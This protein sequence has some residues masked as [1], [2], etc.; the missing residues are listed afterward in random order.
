MPDAHAIRATVERYVKLINDGDAEG[1]VAL[2][3]ED[4][5]LE[6]PVGGTVTRGRAALGE[7][8]RRTAGSVKLALSGPI[9]VAGRE[10][11]F[12]MLGTLGTDDDP[13][14]LDIVDV[15]SVD[16]AGRIASVRAFWSLDALRKG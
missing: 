1:I 12:P 8:Y 9:R 14:C 7:W 13:S 6:D 11:A 3:A 5:W 2:Y 4:G 15:M 10:A 16:D